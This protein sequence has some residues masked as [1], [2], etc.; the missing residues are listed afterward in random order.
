ME[1]RGGVKSKR[2][3][4]R[5]ETPSAPPE[6]F[7]TAPLKKDKNSRLTVGFVCQITLSQKNSSEM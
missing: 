2:S 3:P 4:C 5:A 1:K 6:F 7:R